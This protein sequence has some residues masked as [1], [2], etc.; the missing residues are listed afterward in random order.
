MKLD[1]VVNHYLMDCRGKSRTEFT[2]HSYGQHLGV[3][4]RLLT[5]ICGLPELEQVTIL[6]LLIPSIL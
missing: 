4:V 6:H 1:D 3:L 2:L 5:D